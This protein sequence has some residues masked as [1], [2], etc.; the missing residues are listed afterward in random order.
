MSNTSGFFMAVAF[1][2]GEA[3]ISIKSGCS[4]YRTCAA[5]YESDSK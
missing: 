1:A 3:K 4:P 2:L 5:S